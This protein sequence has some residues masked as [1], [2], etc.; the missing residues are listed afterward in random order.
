MKNANAHKTYKEATNLSFIKK[1]NMFE[2]Y[3]ENLA[4]AYTF[5]L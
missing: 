5:F 1:K 3:I 2:P 4:G